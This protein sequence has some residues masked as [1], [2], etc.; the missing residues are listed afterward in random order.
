[1]TTWDDDRRR[2]TASFDAVAE[3]YREKFSEEFDHKPFDRDLL[4]RVAQQ[5]PLDQPVL[6][7]GAGPAHVSR[8]IG[9]QSGVQ[10]IASDAA[11]LQLREARVLDPRRALVVADLAQLP[12]RAHE[13]GGIIAFYCLIFGPPEPLDDVFTDWHRAL[14]PGALVVIAVHAGDGALHA[15]EWLGHAVDLTV[16]KRDP[17][18]LVARLERNGFAIQEH[19]VRPPYPDETTDRC[20]IV[21]TAQ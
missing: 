19:A 11:P 5:L 12:V 16:V 8:F 21:A 20:Y 14:R 15:D 9:R 1:V 6:E 18:D 17:D 10:P 13:L 3:P 7:V 4:V 2:A